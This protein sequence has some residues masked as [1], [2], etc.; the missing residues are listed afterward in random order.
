LDE[1]SDFGMSIITILAFSG[2]FSG[3]FSSGF[4]D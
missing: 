2:R 4:F 3:R 1:S